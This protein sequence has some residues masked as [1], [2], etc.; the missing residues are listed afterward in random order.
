MLRYAMLCDVMLVHEQQERQ[1][2]GGHARESMPRT[3]FD[4]TKSQSE[5]CRDQNIGKQTELHCKY[6]QRGRGVREV[7]L[8]ADESSS[9]AYM[10]GAGEVV[11][12]SRREF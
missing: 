9:I 11:L 10:R 6:G 4:E 8:G 7:A 5:Y 3:F 12:A 2:G 1:A